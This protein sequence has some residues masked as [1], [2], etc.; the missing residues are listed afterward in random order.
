MISAF[1]WPLP[2]AKE[3]FDELPSVGDKMIFNDEKYVVTKRAIHDR[4]DTPDG[5]VIVKL[6]PATEEVELF[7]ES[8]ISTK[9]ELKER[10]GHLLENE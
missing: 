2:E 10:A 4:I 6:A 9:E 8:G 1:T 5:K 3:K 7:T